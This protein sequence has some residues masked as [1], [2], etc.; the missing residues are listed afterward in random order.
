[1]K[2]TP[3]PTDS[4]AWLDWVGRFADLLQAAPET[5]TPPPE[6]P[7]QAGKRCLVFAPHPDDECI[8]GALP[9]RLR[10]ESGWQVLNVAV[11]LGSLATRR[12]GRLRELR[13]AC[14]LLG[15]DLHCLGGEQGLEQV[16][17][18]TAERQP[19]LWQAHLAQTVALLRDQE[20]ALVL[21]PHAADHNPTHQGVHRLLCEALAAAGYSGW[22]AQTEFWAP[23]SAPSLMVQTGVADTARLV[24]A[25]ACHVGEVERNPYHL[26]LPAWMADNVRRGGELM[27]GAGSAPPTYA[28]ATLYALNRW[29]DGAPLPS[30]APMFCDSATALD[31]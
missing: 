16:R 26:R 21:F 11:T 29:A 30:G 19:A 8:V 12:A 7:A 14:A 10:Q 5:A 31:L 2:T 22:A 23:Q 27:A 4:A 17:P 20:P 13:Q 9:L 1:M 3:S 28:F 18:E 15:F 24:Q 25:L 6:R